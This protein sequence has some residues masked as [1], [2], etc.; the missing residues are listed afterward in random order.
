MVEDKFEEFFFSVYLKNDET[1]KRRNVEVYALVNMNQIKMVIYNRCQ[2][3][4]NQ[5][6]MEQKKKNQR[7]NI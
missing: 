6:N 4:V 3:R 7:N 1:E 2:A 5:D